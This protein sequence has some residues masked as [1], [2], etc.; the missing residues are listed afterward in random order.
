[1]SVSTIVREIV[2]GDYTN[3]DLNKIGD[4]IRF[5]RNQLTKQ[6]RRSLVV[7]TN[8]QFTN[9]RTG[10]VVTGR[11]EK[12]ALKFATVSTPSG[13]WKVPASMLTT[14]GE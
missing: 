1:M 8:V 11:V 5:A 10:Q 6:N 13:R 2:A 4:A 7:G 14:L 9:T 12:M 3:E